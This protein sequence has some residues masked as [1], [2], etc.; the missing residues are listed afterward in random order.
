MLPPAQKVCS[1]LNPNPG[2]TLT[3]CR[4]S[5]TRCCACCAPP[6]RARWLVRR[7]WPFDLE[8]WRRCPGSQLKEK[9]FN[10]SLGACPLEIVTRVALRPPK[11][12]QV[13][14]PFAVPWF[15]MPHPACVL[16]TVVLSLDIL[17]HKRE[18]LYTLERFGVWYTALSFLSFD[19]GPHDHSVPAVSLPTVKTAAAS[20]VCSAFFDLYCVRRNGLIRG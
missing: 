18:E 5:R 8:R 2:P 19:S 9:I 7:R 12:R 13:Y 11:N 1:C 20:H 3:R 4:C 6:R 14:A 15:K 17:S 10:M 16:W